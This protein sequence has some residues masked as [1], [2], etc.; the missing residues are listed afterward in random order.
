[1]RRPF[2]SI[3]RPLAAGQTATTSQS[4]VSPPILPRWWPVKGEAEVEAEVEAD[5]EAGVKGEA[6]AAEGAAEAMA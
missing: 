5:V 2:A 4:Q 3:S 1:M 6:G